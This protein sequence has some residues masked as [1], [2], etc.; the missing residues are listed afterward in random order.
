MKL[1][2]PYEAEQLIHLVRR[3]P[4]IGDGWRQVSPALWVPVL[5]WAKQ[6]PMDIDHDN[7]R[8]RLNSDGNVLVKYLKD[9]RRPS[10]EKEER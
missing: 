8:V 10:Q 6:A 5:H 7:K 1:E 2:M 9:P 4:D 3:S